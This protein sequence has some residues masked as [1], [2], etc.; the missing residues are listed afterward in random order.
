MYSEKN[1]AAY[2]TRPRLLYGV[3][4]RDRAVSD[5]VHREWHYN[6]HFGKN[7]VYHNISL[8]LLLIFSNRKHRRPICR[9]VVNA[10][11]MIHDC[12]TL[13][14]SRVQSPVSLFTTLRHTCRLLR[15]TQWITEAMFI[16]L[17]ETWTGTIHYTITHLSKLLKFSDQHVWM[18][19]DV[20]NGATR[21][22]HVID[23]IS[24]RVLKHSRINLCCS[25]PFVWPITNYDELVKITHSLITFAAEIN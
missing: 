23:E 6:Q 1:Y 4:P 18:I 16:C 9:G 22:N 25:Y 10:S 20:Y 14:V 5:S 24:L 12:E 19:V 8:Y 11:T 21:V 3:D 7:I 15:I 13:D 2:A 17:H